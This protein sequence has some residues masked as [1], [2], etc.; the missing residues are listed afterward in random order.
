MARYVNVVR[1]SGAYLSTDW[2]VDGEMGISVWYV[3]RR[4]ICGVCKRLERKV[5]R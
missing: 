5:G 4:D 3:A 1:G 2:R